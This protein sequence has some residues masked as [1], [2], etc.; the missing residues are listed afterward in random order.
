MAKSIIYG[1][2]AVQS[3]LEHD[4]ENITN[5]WIDTEKPNPR[6]MALIRQAEQCK[7]PI[8]TTRSKQLERLA[9]T[10][11]HQHVV[12]EYQ[13][14]SQYKESDLDNILA[15]TPEGKIPFILALD[16]V[17]DPHNLGACLR[18]A[19]GAGVQAVIVPKDNAVGLT[20]TVRK[21][22][23]GAAER[24]PL[25]SVTNL[26]RTLQSLKKQ[27]LWVIATSDK[28]PSSLY[29]EDL[30]IPLVF[31]MGA[32]GKGIRPLT[33]K[34]CDLLVSLPMQG[35]VSSLNVSVA[36]GIC[37]YEVVRQRLSTI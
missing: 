33:E 13:V 36:S 14:T 32:E 1:I 3:A 15:S 24:I 22:A 8:Q 17:T 2:H 18:T 6:L 25:I 35:E 37:L 29:Q 12:A 31:V 21:V 9:N 5:L 4:P 19:E 7:L 30:T 34:H 11:N 26:S 10:R 28:A 27:G 20:P 16:G 23:S